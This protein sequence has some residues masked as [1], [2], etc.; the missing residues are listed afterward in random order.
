MTIFHT[1]KVRKCTVRQ[2][3]RQSE[4]YKAAHSSLKTNTATSQNVTSRAKDAK[5]RN[6]GK[7]EIR[8]SK[9]GHHEITVF[10]Y[11]TPCS[12]VDGTDV[13][14]GTSASIVI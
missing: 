3:R 5:K 7:R 13:E 9:S 11:V 10:W 1:S 14:E 6:E 8:D 4:Q 12:F 2:R